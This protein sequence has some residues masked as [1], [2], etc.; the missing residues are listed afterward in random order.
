MSDPDDTAGEGGLADESAF[1]DS[2]TIV[3]DRDPYEV[4]DAPPK[5]DAEVSALVASEMAMLKP[6]ARKIAGQSGPRAD[7]DELFSVGQLA[8][9]TAARQH[10]ARQAPFGPYAVQRVRWAMFT[11]LRKDHGRT[12]ARRATA[13]LALE[14]ASTV[15][16]TTVDDPPPSERSYRDRLRDALSREATALF[17]G[18]TRGERDTVPESEPSPESALVQKRANEALTAAVKKLPDR[19]REIIERHYFAGERF[20][21]IAE[22][23]GVS[24]SWL[25][26][27]H[28]KALG[29]L[30]EA[31]KD[32]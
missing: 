8:L 17:I 22:R 4:A 13:L 28:G 5:T 9:V 25:S 16:A 29:A 26:R 21:Q 30:G 10:D 6:L 7:V 31:L 2:D 14:S 19:E 27:L 23:F 24:K 15:S 3:D 20:D 32:H 18:L 12:A 1:S 11:S